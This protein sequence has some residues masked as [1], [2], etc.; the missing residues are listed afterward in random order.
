MTSKK[1]E[2]FIEPQVKWANSEAK[3]LLH[4]DIVNSMVPLDSKDDDRKY[5]ETDGYP[6]RSN[7][8]NMPKRTQPASG[9]VE[10]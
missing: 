5:N 1:K 10:Q 3:K 8:R 4:D 7:V 9:V 6:A 2:V